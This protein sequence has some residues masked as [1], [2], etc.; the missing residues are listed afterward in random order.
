MKR[1]IS[2]LALI[3]IMAA[4]LIATAV[5]VLAA[6]ESKYTCTY[7]GEPVQSR[8]SSTRS[9]WPSIPRRPI[10]ALRIRERLLRILGSQ[11]RISR[12]RCAF[13]YL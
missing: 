10:T 6:P 4:M 3:A 11:R 12:R 5:P 13:F 9:W 8:P 2:M 1:V 7:N